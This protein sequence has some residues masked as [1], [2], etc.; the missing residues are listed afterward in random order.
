[1]IDK[2]KYKDVTEKILKAAFE[3]HTVLKNGFAEV[4]YHRAMIIESNIQGLNFTSEYEVG[5]YYKNEKVGARRVDLFYENKIPVELKATSALD[6]I[7]LAQAINYLEAFNLEIGM[8][9]NFGAKSLEY[10]RLYNAKYHLWLSWLKVINT[11]K[12]YQS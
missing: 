7:H 1:M 3:V 10:R 6:D 12:P 2:Y 11:S 8:L 9:L 5:I 4:V